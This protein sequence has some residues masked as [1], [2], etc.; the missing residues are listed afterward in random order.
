[1]RTGFHVD[2]KVRVRY[3]RAYIGLSLLRYP[4]LY[5]AKSLIKVVYQGLESSKRLLWKCG[6]QG[7]KW[8]FLG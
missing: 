6:C 2:S 4:T 8:E 7:I 1:M 3:G 5:R